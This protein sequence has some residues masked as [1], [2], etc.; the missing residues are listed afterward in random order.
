MHSVTNSSRHSHRNSTRHHRSI[1]RD[2]DTSSCCSESNGS[3]PALALLPPTPPPS[4]HAAPQQLASDTLIPE[5]S[6]QKRLLLAKSEGRLKAVMAEFAAIKR[7]NLTLNEQIYNIVLDAHAALRKEGTPV[8]Q[9]LEGWLKRK[10][11]VRR[12]MHLA[13]ESSF[14][15]VSVRG[16]AQSLDHAQRRYVLYLDPDIMQARR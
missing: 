1:R 6:S 5:S 10:Q 8:G 4:P 11:H 3:K 12:F 14:F 16:D 13:D 7:Q 9:M 2:S 15:V